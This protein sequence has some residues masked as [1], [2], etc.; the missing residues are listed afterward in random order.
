MVGEKHHSPT[1][2]LVR[3]AVI[4]TMTADIPLGLKKKGL[5][6]LQ[7]VRPLLGGIVGLFLVY[8]LYVV[9]IVE[10]P[11][12]PDTWTRL[13]IA[14]IILGGVYSLIAIG[15]TMVFGIIGMVNFAHGDVFMLSA[16]IALLIFLPHIIWEIAKGFPTLEFMHN[17]SQ[18][19]NA[20]IGLWQFVGGQFN[21]MNYINGPLWVAG[22]MYF[23]LDREGSR[24]RPLAWMYVIVFII[25][26][27]GNGKVYYLSAAYPV[28]LAGGA[29]CLEKLIAG[30]TMNRARDRAWRW[31]RVAYPA[32]LVVWMLIGLPFTLPVL[33][34]EKFIGYEK[35][36][37]LMP[38]AEERSS[39]GELPQF[40]ADQFGWEELTAAVDACARAGIGLA[41]MKVQGQQQD[42]DTPE[43]AAILQ[44]LIRNGGKA[45][46]HVVA[47]SMTPARMAL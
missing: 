10:H 34:V 35:L 29:V 3:K 2:F 16:F 40:Y 1:T 26:V 46:I 11:Y 22:L 41:A 32:L 24:F 14:G 8:R 30:H 23:F 6:L 47:V 20:K 38:K 4:A 45:S 13:L 9:L 33:P 37:G 28:L 43:Q 36:L 5:Q 17:A 39:V 15:Y 27:A 21:G 44:L 18:F 7:L 31:V 19:K 12:G 25:M 42:A